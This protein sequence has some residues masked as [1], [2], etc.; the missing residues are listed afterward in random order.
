MSVDYQME[1]DVCGLMHRP[2]DDC[3]VAVAKLFDETVSIRKARDK[4]LARAE[5]AEARVKDLETHQEQLLS[6]L[7]NG[8]LDKAM[9][10]MHKWKEQER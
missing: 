8:R 1:C 5:K 9:K 10:Y 6:M 2:V 4:L 3:D 7:E